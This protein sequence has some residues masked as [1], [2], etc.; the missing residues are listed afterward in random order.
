MSEAN[1]SLMKT[2]AKRPVPVEE[3]ASAMLELFEM[4]VANARDNG[5]NVTL[6]GE[7]ADEWKPRI[8]RIVNG[9]RKTQLPQE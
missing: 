6:L 3:L 7:W 1:P 4:V 9:S 2:A 5:D 8:E